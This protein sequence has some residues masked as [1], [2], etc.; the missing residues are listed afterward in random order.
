MDLCRILVEL[1]TEGIRYVV[2][3]VSGNEQNTLS[4]TRQEDSQAAADLTSNTA[5]QP[6]GAQT[7]RW[8]CRRRLFHRQISTSEI[9]GP[10]YC[11]DLALVEGHSPRLVAVSCSLSPGPES[12]FIF[13]ILLF[14]NI[15][16]NWSVEWKTQRGKCLSLLMVVKRLA[17]EYLMARQGPRPLRIRREN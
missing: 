4:H 6:I 3:R 9:S 8:F 11:L 16:L 13:S 1:L 7:C 14:V 12:P 17:H 5:L 15:S 10:V 2:G